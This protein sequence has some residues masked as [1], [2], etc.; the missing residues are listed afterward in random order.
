MRKS[1]NGRNAVT[2]PR[3]LLEAFVSSV[4]S[5]RC[6]PVNAENTEVFAENTE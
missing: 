3:V 5:W 6:G 4:L 1:R 2:P